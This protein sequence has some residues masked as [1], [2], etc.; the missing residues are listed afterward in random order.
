[1]ADQIQIALARA[2]RRLRLDTLVKLRWFAV[3]GQGLAIAFVH[4][5]LGFPVPVAACVALIA[6]SIWLN[7]LL[8][9]RYPMSHRLGDGAALAL[10]AYDVLQLGALLYLTGGLENPFSLL[11]LAPVLISAT[12]QPPR[13]TLALGALVVACASVLAFVHLPLPWDKNRPLA[14]PSLYIGGIWVA[15]LLGVGF[16]AVYAWRVSAEADDLAEALAAAEMVMAREQ[17][18]SQLDGLAAAA[19]HELGTPLATITLVAK[20]IANAAP[21]DSAL[22]EDIA[23]LRQ[24]VDRCRTILSTLTSLDEDSGPLSTFVLS[25]LL[26]EI[27]GP[28]RP[29]GVPIIVRVEGE[30][31]EPV[32]RRNP[33]VLYGVG[34]LVDNAVDFASSGVTLSGRWSASRVEIEVS[35]DGPGFAPE[36][37]LRAGEPYITSR[38]RSRGRGASMGD[39]RTA[40]QG[41]G[42]GLFIAKTLLER[43]GA[44]VA[45][46]NHP[47]ERGGARI[48]VTWPRK[49]FEVRTGLVGDAGLEHWNPMPKLFKREPI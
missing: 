13:H 43:A 29:F 3:A 16:T 27:A 49:A 30:G 7:I 17:H 44:Q 2:S 41:L 46:A 14:L 9:L 12:A 25:Q 22:A 1:M 38:G 33:S 34:N 4:L 23:L 5:G 45:F 20:E 8:R 31:E 24:E 18:L 28:Q 39:D 36:I 6:V 15:I 37:L 32:M 11:F 19:A 10:L 35:D 47:R 40:R 26:E 21:P 48:T 42:L